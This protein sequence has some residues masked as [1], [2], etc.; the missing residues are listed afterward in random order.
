[1]FLVFVS[2]NEH[3]PRFPP[4]ERKT[5]MYLLVQD[6]Q[7]FHA[8]EID[9]ARLDEKHGS[10]QRLQGEPVMLDQNPPAI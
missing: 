1:L 3:E 5:E 4:E 8:I 6:I 7:Q 10:D 9:L 2:L